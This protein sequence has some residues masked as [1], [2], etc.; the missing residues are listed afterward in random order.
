MIKNLLEYQAKDKERLELLLS[1]ESGRAKR[2]INAANKILTDVRAT[3]L[4]LEREAKDLTNAYATAQKSLGEH[5]ERVEKLK[6]QS[7]AKDENDIQ[8]S[9]A[10][11][12]TLLGEIGALENKLDG[13]SKSIAQKTKAFENTKAAGAKAQATIKNFTPQYQEQLDKIKPKLDEV[14]AQLKKIA[15]TVDAGLVEKYKAR[16][17]TEPFGKTGDIVIAVSKGR[18]GACLI[19][20]PLS[21]VHKIS[22]DGYIICE[23]CGKI[24]Y[25]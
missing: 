24:L 14:E 22:T 23:E 2:E 13:I 17:K 4:E 10:Y 16:R 9:L 5:L 7:D 18:C 20:M 11:I 6:K 8:S 15:A 3:I 1:V 21:L 12:S 19:E 25:A